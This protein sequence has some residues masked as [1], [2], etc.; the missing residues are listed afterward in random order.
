MLY[1]ISSILP[2]NNILKIF[3]L[4]QVVFNYRYLIYSIF[5]IIIPFIFLILI[6]WKRRTKHYIHMNVSGINE[7]ICESTNKSK[8]TDIYNKLRLVTN[9]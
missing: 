6:Y 5:A 7:K 3:K 1:K 2:S 8:V 4:D 9:K